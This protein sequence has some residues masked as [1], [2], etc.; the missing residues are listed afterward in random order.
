[1]IAGKRGLSVT[2]QHAGGAIGA[3]PRRRCVFLWQVNVSTAKIPARCDAAKGSRVRVLFP[4]FSCSLKILVRQRANV[5][6][7]GA[8][9]AC[10]EMQL[11]H[12]GGCAFLRR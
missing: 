9:I 6:I 5:W 2:S 8:R 7:G 12:V 1:M 3:G 4:F 11:F 10:T